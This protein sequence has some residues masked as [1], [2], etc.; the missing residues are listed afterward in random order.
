MGIVV[1]LAMLLGIIF[2]LFERFYTYS[3]PSLLMKVS[4]LFM[5]AAGLWNSVWYGLQNLAT[6]WGLAGFVSRSY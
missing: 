2:L 1:S 3:K 4:L 5:L 6:F